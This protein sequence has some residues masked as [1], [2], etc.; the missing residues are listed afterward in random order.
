MGSSDCIEVLKKSGE[1]VD[2]GRCG[3]DFRR[4][5]IYETAE[6]L[7]IAKIELQID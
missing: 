4:Q 2:R 1:L 5:R 3:V 6:E 7:G